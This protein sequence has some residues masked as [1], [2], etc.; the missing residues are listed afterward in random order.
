MIIVY[1]LFELSRL[2]LNEELVRCFLFTV[3]VSQK[4]SP[5]YGR[6][7]SDGHCHIPVHDV[8]TSESGNSAPGDTFYSAPARKERT[9][10]NKR[11][12]RHQREVSQNLEIVGKYWSGLA[13]VVEHHNSL[14]EC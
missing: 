3:F 10:R 6:N 2:I 14:N 12:E 13:H 8:Y 11:G 4:G 9:G 5:V 1:F 7:P